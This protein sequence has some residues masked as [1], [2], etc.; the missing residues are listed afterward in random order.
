MSAYVMSSYWK[1]CFI[2]PKFTFIAKLME[3]LQWPYFSS[4]FQWKT[5]TI[6]R[7]LGVIIRFHGAQTQESGAGRPLKH[8]VK[9]SSDTIHTLLTT[10]RHRRS[11]QYLPLFY[12]QL[13]LSVWSLFPFL[14]S[15]EF[16]QTDP[17]SLCM[18]IFQRT[19][20][21]SRPKVH[22]VWRNLQKVEEDLETC[23]PFLLVGVWSWTI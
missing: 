6:C 12:T 18:M 20:A 13:L 9:S 8:P 22:L 5:K 3:K 14:S 23:R 1:S 7:F 4:G 21:F 15:L 19:T 17:V 16:I 2:T 11:I 10:T